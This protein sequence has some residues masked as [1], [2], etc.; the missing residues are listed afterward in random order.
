MNT[1]M[2][3][4]PAVQKNVSTLGEYGVELVGPAQGRL[5]CGTE[6]TGRMAEPAEIIE[7]IKKVARQNRS[8]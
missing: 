4:N 7:A 2:W 5:A 6:G 8:G 3:N 1:N